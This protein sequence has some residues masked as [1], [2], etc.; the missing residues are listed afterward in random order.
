MAARID[1]YKVADGTIATV[2]F[3]AADRSVSSPLTPDPLGTAGAAG[4]VIASYPD[5]TALAA[6][7]GLIAR[8]AVARQGRT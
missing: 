8:A 7:A 1:I 5:Q 2:T 4:R 3:N 6:D